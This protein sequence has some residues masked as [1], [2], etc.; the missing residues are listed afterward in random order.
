M[1]NR[2]NLTIFIILSLF[3]TIGASDVLNLFSL[4]SFEMDYMSEGLYAYSISNMNKYKMRKLFGLL[5]IFMFVINIAML[6]NIF[7][8]YFVTIFFMLLS[9]VMRRIKSEKILTMIASLLDR[10]GLLQLACQYHLWMRYRISYDQLDLHLVLVNFPVMAYILIAQYL[11]Y[12]MYQNTLD[13]IVWY[14]LPIYMIMSLSLVVRVCTIF[15]WEIIPQLLNNRDT[16][17][18]VIFY[19]DK[20]YF[21]RGNLH[22]YPSPSHVRK[23]LKLYCFHEFLITCVVTCCG[24]FACIISY[25]ASVA[26]IK[27][28]LAAE[29]AKDMPEEIYCLLIFLIRMFVP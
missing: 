6:Q 5:L 23:C 22:L 14:I 16:A 18:F 4:G 12:L 8:V 15:S 11:S 20:R 17:F 9:S 7:G 3:N 19:T 13:D 21:S 2:T 26:A 24:V 25:E 27:N 10:Y 1:V 29:A 28:T